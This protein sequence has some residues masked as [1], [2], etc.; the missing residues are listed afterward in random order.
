M[1][2]P[3]FF[4]LLACFEPVDAFDLLADFKGDSGPGDFLGGV[5]GAWL[6]QAGVK[7][8]FERKKNNFMLIKFFINFTHFISFQIF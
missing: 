3:A 8:A 5:A 6:E 2:K 4:T 1:I 7:F